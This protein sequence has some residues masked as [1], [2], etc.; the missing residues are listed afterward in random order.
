MAMTSYTRN[1]EDVLIQR[2]LGSVESGCYLDVGAFT[3]VGDSN[4]YALYTRGWRGLCVEPQAYFDE[5]WRRERPEDR[6]VHVL[7][8]A[9]DGEADL[10]EVLPHAQLATQSR[11]LALEHES[12]YGTQPIA[13]RRMPVRRL[14]SLVDEHL[15]AGQQIHLAS[16]D[17]EG[18][19]AE[20]LL[21]L[22]F[23]RHRPW[24]MVVEAVA[25]G[26]QEPTQE[27]WEPRLLDSGYS[28][29]WFDGVNRF[30]VAREHP[31]LLESLR[32]PPN[33]WD[34]FRDHFAETRIRELE[35]AVLELHSALEAERAKGRVRSA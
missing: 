12:T 19:E 11:A 33:V 13:T 27:A 20:A 32:V 16:I 5:D 3:P 21:G 34:D 1:R 30:Y 28:M 35:A 14:S 2:A 25:P 29:A 17:V 15:L 10:Y 6:L 23:S 4:T 18:A 22:D 31:E 24:L 9:R 26:R 7:A 8:G